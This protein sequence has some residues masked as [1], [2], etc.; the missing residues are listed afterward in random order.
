[1]EAE[2]VKRRA[3]ESRFKNQDTQNQK[4]KDEDLAFV[5][6]VRWTNIADCPTFQQCFETV[7]IVLVLGAKSSA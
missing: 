2:E 1:L 4:E 3:A 6:S 5:R 7:P